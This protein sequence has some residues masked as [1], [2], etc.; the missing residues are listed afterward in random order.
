MIINNN[1]V[2]KKIKSKTQKLCILHAA[3][4]LLK[5]IVIVFYGSIISSHVIT[6]SPIILL[7]VYHFHKYLYQNSKYNLFYTHDASLYFCTHI[8][9]VVIPFLIRITFSTIKFTVYYGKF[10]IF[11][12]LDSL[13]FA[14]ILKTCA[15]ITVLLGMYL[16]PDGSSRVL[17]LLSNPSK[18]NKKQIVTQSLMIFI[19]IQTTNSKSSYAWLIF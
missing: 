2:I 3:F 4:L 15:F 9:I 17:Q 8:D 19:R 6:K 16:L 13:I 14:I 7:N 10:T 18:I 12:V 11:N 1:M 5:I